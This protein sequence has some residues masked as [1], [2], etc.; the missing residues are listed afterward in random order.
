MLVVPYKSVF[1]KKILPLMLPHLSD[2]GLF[3][4]GWP[5]VGITQFAKT[6]AMLMGIYWFA[7]RDLDA[8]RMVSGQ[9]VGAFQESAT[10][11]SRGV[12]S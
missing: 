8:C 12:A 1:N 7:A 4:P 6:V 5:G 3:I 11:N 2:V 10:T 9:Q